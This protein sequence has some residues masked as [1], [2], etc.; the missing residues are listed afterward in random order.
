MDDK[1]G[2]LR[3]HAAHCRFMARSA[4]SERMRTILFTMATE[5]DDQADAINAARPIVPEC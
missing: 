3:R 1:A 5:F 2:D 4:L